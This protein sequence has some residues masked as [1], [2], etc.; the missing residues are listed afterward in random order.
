MSFAGLRGQ[1]RKQKLGGVTGPHGTVVWQHHRDA[2]IGDPFVDDVAVVDFN[3]M[4]TGG[5]CVGDK[6][7]SL[8]YWRGGGKVTE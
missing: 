2:G 5:S 8:F 7:A 1:K 6:S 3:E 4:T